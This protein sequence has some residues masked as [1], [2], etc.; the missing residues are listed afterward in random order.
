MRQLIIL[1][2]NFA[3]MHP[4][5]IRTHDSADQRSHPQISSTMILG[6]LSIISSYVGSTKQI[7]QIL[8]PP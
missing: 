7:K 1:S 5:F 8:E 4:L 2:L 6:E 3:F